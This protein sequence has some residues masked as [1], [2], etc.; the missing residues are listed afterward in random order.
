MDINNVG[1]I[2]CGVMG[3]GIVQVC[4]QSGYE[5]TVLEINNELLNKGLDAIKSA[6]SKSVSKGQLSQEDCQ[7]VIGRIKGTTEA[8]D[9]G[10]CDLVIEASSENMDLKKRLFAE[11]DRVC[12][13]HT[14]L[15]TN[16]SCLS[17]I[18]IAMATSRPEKVISLHFMNPAPVMKL[19]EVVRT[20]ATSDATMEISRHFGKSLGKNI[21]VVQDTPGFVVN[22]LLIPFIIHAISLF[23]AGLATKEDIDTG[24][25]LGLG[26]PMG[27]LRL[28]DLIGLDIVLQITEYI[29]E[30]LKDPRYIKPILL[31]KMISAGWLGRKTG[32]G[33][34]EYPQ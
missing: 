14:I 16:T 12:P 5:V 8:R 23:E 1:V 6:L 11:V 20:V 31:K 3:G 25:S 19:L 15:A 29:Y 28:A 24:V 2:G 18:E 30:E 17:V 4:A 27:P 34:Y 13:E 26:H 9:F 7:A 22:R 21:I 33:F 32:R 10:H